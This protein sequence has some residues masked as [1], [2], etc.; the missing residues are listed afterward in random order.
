MGAGDQLV[1][2]VNWWKSEKCDVT[3]DHL[4]HPLI[5]NLL[6]SPRSP[7]KTTRTDAL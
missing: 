1:V 4:H 7:R 2:S 5:A 3:S 6:V